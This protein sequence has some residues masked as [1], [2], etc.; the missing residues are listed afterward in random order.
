[1]AYLGN[2]VIAIYPS[3]LRPAWAMA[4][5]WASQ[6]RPT[7]GAV[8]KSS[9]CSRRRRRRRAARRAHLRALATSFTSSQGLLLM[10]PTST[11]SPAS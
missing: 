9:K 6:A 5:E 7:V 11:R 4:D 1:M 3:R 2:E 8:P 10:I